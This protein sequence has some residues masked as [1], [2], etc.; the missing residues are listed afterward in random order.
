[1]TSTTRSEVTPRP[2]A[3]SSATAPEAAG[4]WWLNWTSARGLAL[5]VTGM[6][7]MVGPREEAV[8]VTVVVALF[9]LWAAGELWAV[10][11]NRRRPPI[12][13]TR[14]VPSTLTEL[15]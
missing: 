2:P 7:V 10:F 1:M 4:R 5:I 12:A 13:M 3:K 15:D 11:G 6:A 8:V 14:L 9:A